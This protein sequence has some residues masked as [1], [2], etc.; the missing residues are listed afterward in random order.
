M[1]ENNNRS[2]SINVNTTI[3]PWYSSTCRLTIGAWNDK[4]SLEFTPCTGQDSNGY[5]TYDKDKKVNTAL[6]FENSCMLSLAI[7]K[8]LMPHI[9]AGDDTE[10]SVSV[11]TGDKTNPNVIQ[12]AREKTEDGTLGMSITFMKGVG[13]DGKA[14]DA[15]VINKFWFNSGEYIV[16]YDCNSGEHVGNIV[17][18]QFL[19][20]RTILMNHIKMLSMGVHATK[21][22]KA[23]VDRLNERYGSNG[24]TQPYTA[25]PNS[26][27]MTGYSM[28]D[29]LPFS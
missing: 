27:F 3:I 20:F 19:A 26:G 21:Y 28:P 1:F 9:E 12:I 18:A 29:E 25:P 4:L 8:T 24:P 7:D 6:T 22:S 17:P 13:S 10:T 5:N 14:T 16:D 2:N 15:T 23:I 11:M